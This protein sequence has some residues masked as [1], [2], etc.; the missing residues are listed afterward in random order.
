MTTAANAE[1][2]RIYEQHL[3]PL[4]RT[5]ATRRLEVRAES[6]RTHSRAGYAELTALRAEISRYENQ[7]VALR[8]G[9]AA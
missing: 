4:Y 5:L 6:R 1:A 3:C 7:I 2:V 8:A 9:Q